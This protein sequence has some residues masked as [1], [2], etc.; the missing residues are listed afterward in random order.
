[1]NCQACNGNGEI[2]CTCNTFIHI[3]VIIVMV[4]GLLNV[5]V[6]MVQE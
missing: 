5:L 4:R 6:V 1:M 2:T 3:I